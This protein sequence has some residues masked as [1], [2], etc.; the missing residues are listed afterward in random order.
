M[1]TCTTKDLRKEKIHDLT[2][3]FPVQPI[4]QV[5]RLGLNPGNFPLQLHNFHQ[6]Y[7]LIAYD[8]I[9]YAF[10]SAILV[11]GNKDEYPWHKPGVFVWS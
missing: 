3:E 9:T 2:A 6:S 1:N 11:C 8:R 10:T 4:I 7:A 5:Q